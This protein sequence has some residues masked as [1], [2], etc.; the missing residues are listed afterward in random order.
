MRS[1]FRLPCLFWLWLGKRTLCSLLSTLHV[2][3]I[4]S[5]GLVSGLCDFQVGGPC[6]GGR[7]R[8]LS[9]PAREGTHFDSLQTCRLPSGCFIFR[10]LELSI[11]AH[12]QT[13]IVPRA[14]ASV[15]ELTHGAYPCH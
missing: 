8:G 15:R 12:E 6:I 5:S 2:C 10:F 7:C 1:C 13:E 4:S 14:L 11:D 9:D 3:R